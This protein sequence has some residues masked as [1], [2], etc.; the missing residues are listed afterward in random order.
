MSDTPQVL[1]AH[2]LKALK[3]PSFLREYDKRAQQC[4]G[5]GSLPQEYCKARS[6]CEINNGI[7]LIPDS[8]LHRKFS[9]ISP[10]GI[11]RRGL[12]ETGGGYFERE[13]HGD[14]HCTIIVRMPRP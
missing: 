2:H 7:G 4:A 1:L 3:L 5:G 13:Q 10:A 6:A 11:I 8:C 12:R 9:Q 14:I